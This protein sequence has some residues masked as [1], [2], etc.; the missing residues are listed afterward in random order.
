M[1]TL[2]NIMTLDQ[3]FIHFNNREWAHFF[4]RIKKLYEILFYWNQSQWKIEERMFI[5]QNYFRRYLHSID[6]LEVGLMYL[7][8]IQ[9]HYELDFEKYKELLDVMIEKTEKIRRYRS[10]SITEEDK[11]DWFLI[12]IY[13]ER[14]IFEDKLQNSIRDL[15][16]WLLSE[17]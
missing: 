11:T 3:E 13:K 9:K 10:N 4:P 2:D 6:K 7:D 12:K 15:V 16:I 8:Y 14:D 5:C 1:N 17:F